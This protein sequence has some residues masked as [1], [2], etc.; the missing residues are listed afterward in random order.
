[1]GD[2]KGRLIGHI[3]SRLLTLVTRLVL[4]VDGLPSFLSTDH[5]SIKLPRNPRAGCGRDRLI[6]LGSGHILS[7]PADRGAGNATSI[8]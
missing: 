5:D 6:H 4:G 3:C 7:C 1:M 2:K 8:A